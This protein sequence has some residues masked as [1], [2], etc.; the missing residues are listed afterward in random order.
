L[1]FYF[2]FTKAFE[3]LYVLMLMPIQLVVVIEYFTREDQTKGERILRQS[4]AYMED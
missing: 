1:L 4:K 3:T 2:S